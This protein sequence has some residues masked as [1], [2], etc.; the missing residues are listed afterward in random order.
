MNTRVGINKNSVSRNVAF[1]SSIQRHLYSKHYINLC[2]RGDYEINEAKKRLWENDAI[3]NSK[4]V[5]FV[6][7]KSSIMMKNRGRER[8]E[9]E[10]CIQK[11][12]SET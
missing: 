3:G 11:T 7:R 1:K 10:T 8:V 4:L 9:N 12:K 5:I 6:K 2:C